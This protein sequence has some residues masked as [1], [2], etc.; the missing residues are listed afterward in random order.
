MRY[1]TSTFALILIA[2]ACQAQSQK[3]RLHTSKGNITLLL[4]DDTPKHRDAFIK[5][6]REGQ[7]K[8]AA[9]NRVIKDFVSQ[10]GEL[11]DTILEREKQH[12]EVPLKRIDAEIVATRFHK[13]GALGAGRN[14]NPEKKSFVSQI[15]L[16]AGK[17]FSEQQLNTLAQKKGVQFSAEQRAAYRSVG[18]TPHLDGDYTVFGEIIEGM[19][20]ADAI[21]RVPTNSNDLPVTPLI[22]S[23]EILSAN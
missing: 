15:Y 11:D 12:P 10:A 18:G 5:S 14:E 2:L 16:V 4:Y 9:F 7:Y 1:L 8:D 23:A 17:K 21:N 20:V 6:V 19:D 13:K 3:V 22:F